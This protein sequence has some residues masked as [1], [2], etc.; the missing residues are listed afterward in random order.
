ML[1]VDPGATTITQTTVSAP[2][3]A[4]WSANTGAPAYNLTNQS[5]ITAGQSDVN[6]VGQGTPGT[7][8]SAATAAENAGYSLSEISFSIVRYDMPASF[9]EAM[10]NVLSSG[11]VYR[12]YYDNYSIFSGIGSASK[13]GTTRFSITTKSLNYCI[14][15]FQ[16][17][18]RDTIDAPLNSIISSKNQLEYGHS[19]ATFTNQVCAGQPLTFNSSKYF[20][21]NGSGI[22]QST[23]I[24]GNVRLPPESVLESYN[25][26]LKA[27]GTKNDINGGMYPGCKNVADFVQCYF[28][29]ILSLQAVGENDLY[30]ISGLDSSQQPVSIALEVTGGENVDSAS[31]ANQNTSVYKKDDLA[32]PVIIAA[33]SSHL[34]VTVGRNV[35][36]YS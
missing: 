4:T 14:G 19:A 9:Y 13:S 34:D 35:V 29:T 17:P 1:G 22:K 23:W 16:L 33:Y 30:T 25:S 8:T 10:R 6:L 7:A 36:L 12:L 32:T 26:I 21:R 28:G 3:N 5:L 2:G 24:V 20:V 15:T 18:N 27:F 31:D 11:A